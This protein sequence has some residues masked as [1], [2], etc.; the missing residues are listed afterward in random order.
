MSKEAG[1]GPSLFVLPY[2]SS[3]AV[4]LTSGARFGCSL[5]QRLTLDLQEPNPDSMSV[6][7]ILD[8]LD[9]KMAYT[10]AFTSSNLFT[11]TGPPNN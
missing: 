10:T 5:A 3:I 2:L 6:S 7:R 1:N 11:S 4:W 9:D 8:P